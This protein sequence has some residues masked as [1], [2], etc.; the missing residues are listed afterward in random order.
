MRYQPGRRAET[1]MNFPGTC[2]LKLSDAAIAQALEYALNAT[3][4]DGEDYVHVTDVA[5][6]Y[7]Y[8]P[9][10]VSITT[11]AQPIPAGEVTELKVAA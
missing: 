1:Q 9:W 10:R 8:G 6:E 2:E 4:R 11:D 5:R 3:R 7:S